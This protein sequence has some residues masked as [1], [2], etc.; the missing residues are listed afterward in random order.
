MLVSLSDLKRELGI[1]GTG[2]DVDLLWIIRKVSDVVRSRTK[3]Y[4]H[5][6]LHGAVANGVLMTVTAPGHSLQT[7]D[8][9]CLQ[10]TNSV[11]VLDGWYEITVLDQD[12]FTA[13]VPS[14]K[15]LTQDATLGTIHPRRRVEFPG[16]NQSLVWLP[17]SAC[18]LIGIDE[19]S[20]RESLTDWR[21]LD[22]EDYALS[23]DDSTAKVIAIERLDGCAWSAFNRVD[24]SRVSSTRMASVRIRYYGGMSHIPA[25]L[26]EACLSL[27][28]DLYEQQGVSRGVVQ[29]TS[30][31]LS[32]SRL[33]GLER[34]EGILSPHQII[35][36]W[37]CRMT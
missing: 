8:I 20:V 30:G 6:R 27:C 1:T 34:Q 28:C 25:E 36:N 4:L 9:V 24:S 13:T 3:R 31:G 21:I 26:D 12:R 16:N 37:A 32:R 29:E 18:P 33:T 5:C 23:T 15:V 22:A 11:P 35:S 10:G 14:D 17:E 19:V 2:D 7:K